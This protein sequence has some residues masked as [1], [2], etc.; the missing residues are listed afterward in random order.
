MIKK[1]LKVRQ[2][3]VRNCTGNSQKKNEI[4]FLQFWQKLFYH[5]LKIDNIF[6]S[7]MGKKLD[8]NL[9]KKIDQ[10]LVKKWAKIGKKLIKNTSKIRQHFV[11]NCTRN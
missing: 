11:R 8:K 10:K 7:K 9:S 3:F 6:L 2:Q 5:W 4:S 1:L